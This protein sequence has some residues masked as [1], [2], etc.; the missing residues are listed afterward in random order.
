MLNYFSFKGWICKFTIQAQKCFKDLVSSFWGFYH[1]ML[2]KRMIF[3]SLKLPVIS[4]VV[5][6]DPH[7]ILIAVVKFHLRQSVFNFAFF[8][9]GISMTFLFVCFFFGVFFPAVT[10]DE[11]SASLPPPLLPY[12]AIWSA[13]ENIV[14]HQFCACRFLQQWQLEMYC[15]W[16]L[17]MMVLLRKLPTVPYNICHWWYVGFNSTCNK[18]CLST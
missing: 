1:V 2:W 7:A 9:L 10:P 18:C 12:T 17:L 16:F 15:C 6:T 13:S 8:P 5:T 4:Y 3:P 14:S 11:P